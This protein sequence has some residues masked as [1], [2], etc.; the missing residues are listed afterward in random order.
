MVQKKILELRNQVRKSQIE[1]VE[2]FAT[3][4]LKHKED[5]STGSYKSPQYMI[6]IVKSMTDLIVS[7][8]GYVKALEEKYLPESI[9]KTKHDSNG[10]QKS[11]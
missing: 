1:L 8:Q 10:T 4:E 9:K 2:S 6:P 5:E 7:Y 3:W 11:L